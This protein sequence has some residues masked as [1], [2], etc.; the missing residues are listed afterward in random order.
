MPKPLKPPAELL[1][2]CHRWSHAVESISSGAARIELFQN[3]LPVFLRNQAVFEQ[4]LKNIKDGRPYPDLRQAQMI[5][6]E[7]L[8]YLNPKRLFSLRMFLYGPGDYT[9]IHDH[10]S[11]GVSGA[12]IGELGVIRYIR[13]D[14]G[15]V[16][17]YAQLL[18][19][20]PVYLQ[21]GEIELT[22]PLNEGIHQTG[23]PV[24]G[25]TIMISVYGS[26]IR[27]LYINRFDDKANKVEKLYPPRIKKKMLAAQALDHFSAKE[28]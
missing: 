11:W 23:N 14:D 26:P 8:L 3:E 28:K 17:G 6:D 25:T 18:Q 15:S 27:R 16:E 4:L 10:S 1:K 13:E 19:S 5:D 22:R 7:I 2:I 21:P 12:A 9:P 20:A 24:D